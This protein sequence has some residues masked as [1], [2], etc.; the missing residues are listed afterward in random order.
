MNHPPKKKKKNP[1]LPEENQIDERNLVDLEDSEKISFEDRAA[2]YWSENKG[3]LVKCILILALAIIGFQ[4]MRI[5]KENKEAKIQSKYLA[6]HSSN[7]LEDFV[8]TY[9][10]KPLGGFAALVIADDAYTEENYEKALEFYTSASSTLKDPTLSGRASMGQAFALYNTGKI[11]EG[12]AKLNT[13]TANTNLSEAIRIEAAYHLAVEAHTTGRNEDF[14][15][16]ARQI[17]NAEFASQW[18]QRLALIKN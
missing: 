5:L 13:I 17:E 14:A 15:N 4:G 6:A 2:I 11:E 8:D 12:L 18:Q 10:N 3:F 1:L 9:G 7:A 16:Y